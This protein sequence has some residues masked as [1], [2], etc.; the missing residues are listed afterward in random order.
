MKLVPKRR[1]QVERAR[2]YAGE[3]AQIISALH[4]RDVIY[5]DLK[6]SNVML[7]QAGRLKL[8]DFGLAKVLRDFIALGL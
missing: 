5:R 8:V 7:T 3:L 4:A 2:Y 6:A 1:F